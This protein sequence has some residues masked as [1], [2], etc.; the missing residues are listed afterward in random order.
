MQIVLNK[1]DHVNLARHTGDVHTPTEHIVELTSQSALFTFEDGC[2]RVE[3]KK[4]TLCAY[5]NG[6]PS[7]K[8]VIDLNKLRED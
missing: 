4:V 5:R 3:G 7:Y 1:E 2:I 6:K 8:R